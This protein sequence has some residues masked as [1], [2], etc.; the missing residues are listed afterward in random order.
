MALAQQYASEGH[1]AIAL[2]ARLGELVARDDFNELHT[3]KQ[4]QA[5]VDE[6]NTTRAS[7]RAV[8][9]AAAA[10]SATVA[11]AGREQTVYDEVSEL[12]H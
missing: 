9:L 10:K 2:F 4:H 6:Y 5:I 11:R 12:M 1:D 3:L 8:H 7:L